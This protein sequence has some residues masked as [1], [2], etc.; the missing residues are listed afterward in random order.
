MHHD[1]PISDLDRL[2]T[3]KDAADALG[4][5]YFK[6]QRAARRGLVPTYGM[7]NSRRYVTLRD[8]LERLSAEA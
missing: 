5:P 1:P 8:L 4:I 6:I 3:F 2:R 7:L